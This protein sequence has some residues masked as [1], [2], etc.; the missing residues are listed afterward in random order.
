MRGGQVVLV[1]PAR[2]LCDRSE[3]FSIVAVQ[4]DGELQDARERRLAYQDIQREIPR[5]CEI[6]LRLFDASEQQL[7]ASP[8]QIPLLRVSERILQKRSGSLRAPGHD[9]EG[10]VVVE[11]VAVVGCVREQLL[12]SGANALPLAG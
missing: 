5:G 7:Q 9:L 11:H 1:H 4:R 2:E 6:T 8:R 12:E 3:R 10:S